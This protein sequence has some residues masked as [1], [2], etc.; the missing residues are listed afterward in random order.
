MLVKHLPKL[1]LYLLLATSQT[2]IQQQPHLVSNYH[3]DSSSFCILI[4]YYPKLSPLYLI[5]AIPSIVDD[6]IPLKKLVFSLEHSFFVGNRYMKDNESGR[7]ALYDRN[8][9]IAGIQS[10]ASFLHSLFGK[11]EI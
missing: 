5:Y 8:G 11:D 6:E 7:M 10:A 3:F 9:V 2:S 1:Y 4:L